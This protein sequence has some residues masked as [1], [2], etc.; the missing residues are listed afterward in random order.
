MRKEDRRKR[1]EMEK[2]WRRKRLVEEGDSDKDIERILGVGEEG[3][4]TAVKVESDISKIGQEKYK[5]H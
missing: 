3:G 2:S 5:L 4:S 1:E